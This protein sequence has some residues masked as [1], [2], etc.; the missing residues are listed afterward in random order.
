MAS[1]ANFVVEHSS[2]EAIIIHKFQRIEQRF[3]SL[4]AI[5]TGLLLGHQKL[6]TK[7]AEEVMRSLKLG[8]VVE[9]GGRFT[10]YK[11]GFRSPFLR[12]CVI[13]RVIK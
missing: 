13:L 10:E 12:D 9:V 7:G 6:I 3:S 1:G 11:P 5:D 2:V 4:P 8:Q